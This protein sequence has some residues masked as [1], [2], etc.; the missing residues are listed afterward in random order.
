VRAWWK[1]QWET[2]LAFGMLA[3]FC[4]GVTVAQVAMRLL[5]GHFPVPTYGV[6]AAAITTGVTIHRKRDRDA[7][8]RVEMW[9]VAGDW[10]P[11]GPSLY[12]PWVPLLRKLG[13]VQVLRAWAGPVDG[14]PVTVGELK[15]DENA[16]DGA[17]VGWK[18]QGVFVV[19]RLPVPTE[20][21]AMRR[22]HRT[23]GD[24][25]RLDRPALHDA[26]EDGRIP[27]WTARDQD[28][29]TF[30]AIKGRLAPHDLDDLIRRTLLIVGLL[31]LGPDEADPRPG[32][33]L[34]GHHPG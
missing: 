10:D 1:A 21:M 20:P 34:T 11:T 15:W 5:L 23:L 26:Y 4:G 13:T 22:P 33:E 31:D 28:V 14:L 24:S 18:G 32:T 19:V 3:V 9:V 2:A 27:P 16:L 17:V 6:A 25:H 12:W 8:R 7:R 29:F 30:Q